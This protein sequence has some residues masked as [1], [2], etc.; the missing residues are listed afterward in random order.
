VIVG[1]PGAGKTSAAILL[2]EGLLEKRIDS[3]PVPVI[4]SFSAWDP[5]TRFSEWLRIQI[6]SEYP[7][8]C[9][10]DRFGAGVVARLIGAERILPI[11]DGLDEMDKSLQRRALDVLNTTLGVSTPIVLTSRTSDYEQVIAGG[12]HPLRSA[13]VALLEDIRPDVAARYL[14]GDDP[15]AWREVVAELTTNPYGELAKALSTPL[16]VSAA[17]LTY[18]RP[19]ANPNELIAVP[20]DDA[21]TIAT[22]VI[23]RTIRGAFPDGDDESHRWSEWHRIKGRET[24]WRQRRAIRWLSRYAVGASRTPANGIRWWRF[25]SNGS[26]AFHV[27][28]AVT[29]LFTIGSVFMG[30]Y[31][32]A[33]VLLTLGALPAALQ[34]SRARTPRRVYLSF[35]RTDSTSLILTVARGL[36]V[37]S[38]GAVAFVLLIVLM[39][40]PVACFVGPFFVAMSEPIAVAGHPLREIVP[41]LLRIIYAGAIGGGALGIAYGLLLWIYTPDQYISAASPQALLRSD[42]STA[43]VTGTASTLMLAIPGLSLAVLL[44]HPSAIPRIGAAALVVGV[45]TATS[46]AWGWYCSARVYNALSRN[47]PWRVMRFLEDARDRGLLRRTG[48]VYEFRHRVIQDRLTEVRT[49]GQ[50]SSM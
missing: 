13:P 19:G 40:V 3:E 36:V 23:D 39:L 7:A 18:D 17:R 31:A 16:I 41:L 27:A 5:V 25:A 28:A 37:G 49:F 50:R 35:G 14:S 11:L 43:L 47:A 30:G 12:A 21:V 42:R 33:L 20:H 48:G 34:A 24:H 1:G 2:L 22:S 9:D 32:G 6:E 29:A 15:A 8:L 45:V 44:N 46:T 10:T 26:V 38:G 4:L